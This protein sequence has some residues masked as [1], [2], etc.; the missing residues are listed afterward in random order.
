M[1]RRRVG[2]G[3]G[4]Q[5]LDNIAGMP[6]I[7]KHVAMMPDV[8]LGIGAT[9]GSVIPTKGAIIPAAVGVDIGCG[10]MAVQHHVWSQDLP[11]NLHA[12]R[13]RRS[14]ARAA[15]AAPINGGANDRGAWGRSRPA[16]GDYALA[17]AGAALRR[18]PA[19]APEA[20]QAAS[21][22][23]IIW[24]RSAPATTSSSFASTRTDHVWV[25]LHSGSRGVGN[26]IG[27]YFIELAK[28]DMRRWFINLPDEDLAYFPKAPST[29]SDYIE[30]VGWAQELR[31]REPRGDDGRSPAMRLR[32]SSA[33]PFQSGA[34]GGELPPQLCGARAVTSAQD[35]LVTRK[36]AVRA[37]RG[38]TW[39]SSRA[40]WAP[41][42]HRAR[43]GQRGELLLVLARRRPCDVARAKPSAASRSRITRATPPASNAARTRT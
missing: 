7:F 12:V 40:P 6:F 25:M 11:D 21:A 2:R 16:S 26:R 9:V 27:S 37:R 28:K 42:F 17:C 43:Q 22:P 29:S 39:A 8:H 20:G 23:G 19:E 33:K 18:D 10:M 24:A 5:Q 1:D 38:R 30:A 14:S 34:G 3:P 13:D 32:R 35:V 4:R 31:A 36:G 41:Q 15:W